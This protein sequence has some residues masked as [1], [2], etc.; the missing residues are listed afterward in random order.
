MYPES[1]PG[2]WPNVRNYRVVNILD[3]VFEDMASFSEPGYFIAGDYTK[4]DLVS[5]WGP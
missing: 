3:L 2:P 1:V 5:M 4:L